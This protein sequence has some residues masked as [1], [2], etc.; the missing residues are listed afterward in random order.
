MKKIIYTLI[1]AALMPA[2]LDFLSEAPEEEVV[3]GVIDDSFEVNSTGG[4]N[5]VIPIEVAPGVNNF[6]PTLALTYDSRAGLSELGIG[7]SLAGISKIRRS[8]NNFAQHGRSQGITFTD[9]DAFLLDGQYLSVVKGRNGEARSEYRTENESFRKIYAQG[10]LDNS[11]ASPESFIV[12]LPN[13]TT[14]YYGDED[15]SKLIV[16]VGNNQKEILEWNITRMVDVN[17]NFIHFK[18]KEHQINTI[19]VSSIQ[20]SGNLTNSLGYTNEVFFSYNE[21]WGEARKAND[22]FIAGVRFRNDNVLEKIRIEQNGKPYK[23]Y[24]FRYEDDYSNLTKV[25]E[26]SREDNSIH[27]RPTKIVYEKIDTLRF[28]ERRKIDVP[29]LNNAGSLLQRFIDMDQDGVSESVVFGNEKDSLFIK[30]FKK[31]GNSFK[32]SYQQNLKEKKYSQNQLLGICDINGD[33]YIDLYTAKG[34]YIHKRTSNQMSFEYQENTFNDDKPFSL[35]TGNNG[36]IE[37]NDFNGD[38]KDEL[39]L[40]NKQGSTFPNNHVIIN[41][42]EEDQLALTKVSGFKGA[43][44]SISMVN[45]R[46]GDTQDILV[47]NNAEAKR[48]TYAK[49]KY[50]FRKITL[51]EPNATFK[52]RG[53]QFADVNFDGLDDIVLIIPNTVIA[54]NKQI[55][56]ALNKGTSDGAPDFTAFNYNS[57]GDELVN[58]NSRLGNFTNSGFLELF[59]PKTASEFNVFSVEVKD[60]KTQLNKQSQSLV[61]LSDYKNFPLVNG[62]TVNVPEINL[63]TSKDYQLGDLN[64]DGI[65]DFWIDVKTPAGGVTPYQLEYLNPI[66]FINKVIHV[67]DGFD[68]S[69]Q[70]TYSNT[71]DSTIYK[72]SNQELP[73]NYRYFNRSFDVVKSLSYSNGL[74]KDSVNSISYQYEDLIYEVTG[75]G[76]SGFKAW[77]RSDSSTGII[78]EQQFRIDFPFTGNLSK[79]TKTTADGLLFFEQRNEWELKTFKG[80]GFAESIIVLNDIQTLPKFNQ[81][82]VRYLP[83]LT[84]S[85]VLK[86]ELDG[87]LKSSSQV[88]MEYNS[89]GNITKK[90]TVFNDSATHTELKK[91]SNI[92]S[93]NLPQSVYMIGL[94]REEVSF[95]SSLNSGARTKERVNTF[96]YNNKGL[97]TKSIRQPNSGE[98]TMVTRLK[99]D[100]FG[101]VIS[102]RISG[103]SGEN[104]ISESYQYSADG[105]FMTSMINGAGHKIS[106]KTD[107]RFGAVIEVVDPNGN[108]E[109]SSYDDFGRIASSQASDGTKTTYQFKF[110]KENDQ[111]FGNQSE[112]IYE[113]I[114]NSEKSNEVVS[115]FDKM[116]REVASLYFLTDTIKHKKVNQNGVSTTLPGYLTRPVYKRFVYD[117][118]GNKILDFK[119]V[120]LQRTYDATG[121]ITCTAREDTINAVTS[122]EYDLFNR[123][124]STVLPDGKKYETDYKWDRKIEFNNKNQRVVTLY[125]YRG[126]IAE[127]RDNKNNSTI[128]DYNLWGE[129]VKIINPKKNSI[130]TT[131]DAIGRKTSLTDPNLGK[132]VYSYDLHN[133]QR[134]ETV[135]ESKSISVN[136][137]QLSRVTKKTTADGYTEW[138]Y[139][140]QM[141]GLL[142]SVRVWNQLETKFTSVERYSYD[143]LGR[144]TSLI[145]RVESEEYETKL[146]YDQFSRLKEKTFPGGYKI[147][148]VYKNDQ[149]VEVNEVT[150]SG[151]KLLFKA[152]QL[153]ANGDVIKKKFGNG[154]NTNVLINQYTNL[155]E[156]IYTH[157]LSANL[158]F[159]PNMSECTVLTNDSNSDSDGGLIN[160]GSSTNLGDIDLDALQDLLRNR[161]TDS[162]FEPLDPNDPRNGGTGFPNIPPTIDSRSQLFSATTINKLK[163]SQS[164]LMQVMSIVKDNIQDIRLAYDENDHINRKVDVINV[165]QEFYSYDRLNRIASYKTL[166]GDKLIDSVHLDYDALGNILKKSNIGSYI[167]DP[168]AY[169]RVN[170]IIGTDG[171]M[172]GNY[173]YDDYGNLISN[174]IDNLSIEYASFNKPIKM[175]KGNLKKFLTYG[176]NNQLISTRKLKNDSVLIEST[177]KPF[178][179]YEVV[180]RGDLTIKI[181]YVGINGELVAVHRDE[182]RGDQ[183]KSSNEYIHKDHLGSTSVVTNQDGNVVSEY[184]YDPFGKRSSRIEGKSL[185]RGFTGHEH[186]S[187]FGLINAQGR[188][189]NPEIGRFVSADPFTAVPNNLQSLNRYSY[190]LNNPVN[191]IDPSGFWSLR[192]AIKRVGR[193]ISRA[194]RNVGRSVAKVVKKVAKG[195]ANLAK[196]AGKAIA[197]VLEEGARF[198]KKYATQIVIIA[199]AAAITYF[200]GGSMAGFA[201]AML[202]G[203]AWGAGIGATITAARG[204]NFQDIL[205]AG[206]NGAITGA[207]AGAMGHAGT[208]LSKHV[209]YGKYALGGANGYVSSG[210]ENEGFARGVIS[211]FVP[212]DLGMEATKYNAWALQLGSSAARG[213]II[214]GE[215]GMKTQVAGSIVNQLVGHSSGYIASGGNGPNQFKDGVYIYKSSGEGS[216]SIGGAVTLENGA[217]SGNTIN[218]TDLYD[219]ELK[220]FTEQNSIG[221]IY[222]PAHAPRMI[223]IELL[224]K[225][226]FHSN[227]EGG[228]YDSRH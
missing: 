18:Y 217:W 151:K 148:Y 211:A 226:P 21:S 120:Y 158:K 152:D 119:P 3:F 118:R 204:G 108:K 19:R 61:K 154:V 72:C 130:N 153:N 173:Q 193:S 133:R 200:S 134:S 43:Y 164:G 60:G 136:Y 11:K 42:N 47:F 132:I 10:E 80:S 161:G 9:Q 94:P 49:G 41:L 34:L 116:G 106:Y 17:G 13:G 31:Q 179:D 124:V 160:I 81:S 115:Y 25:Y 131:Y 205:N 169:Q 129:V 208:A 196:A 63:M 220:H 150:D 55:P 83:L 126:D 159:I 223:G 73:G 97:L 207:A 145:N 117:N 45:F 50:E 214:N 22:N 58:Q 221:A 177:V 54:N 192:R 14:L 29:N 218:D 64:D 137:D 178:A 114:T 167:Y 187:D 149:V 75:R 84:R 227:P 170:F 166:L 36:T 89:F 140:G 90:V 24:H 56:I 70:I 184:R 215:E 92:N 51:P 8:G 225:E 7:W 228:R 176:S 62:T 38:G 104:S 101:N 35:I 183:T 85:V 103:Y 111:F 78:H 39:I 186:H 194:V 65:V 139:D 219:H 96:E 188:F 175:E 142:D 122:F 37:R 185:N 52:N 53:Y 98:M 15:N 59:V 16:T 79:E 66:K 165:E 40:F 6:I 163:S 156:R 33:G 201:A 125:N 155:T 199:A 171:I 95:S 46:Q 105:K 197:D 77:K 212:A 28:S 86:K 110:I 181:H 210:G 32:L 27:L 206:L 182:T 222:L 23:Y 195:V 128:Y 87:F 30:V 191:L 82:K 91:Y 44:T 5:H 2:V 190:V 147:S 144:I 180:Q 146:A 135:N 12:K 76:M 202:K 203:A 162:P 143:G 26:S 141:K 57:L 157:K 127:V 121:E 74:K 112:V 99:Y 69:V 107:P 198:V 216:F 1:L 67:K 100:A 168:V 209:Q 213:Y 113:L 71:K 88:L 20:Y 93:S 68:N 172:R 102:K 4:Y 109:R 189:Y 174:E 224:E 48:L 123:V 138:F